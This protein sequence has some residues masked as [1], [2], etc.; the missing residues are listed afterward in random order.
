VCETTEPVSSQRP[1]GRANL[2]EWGRRATA[3]LPEDDESVSVHPG[4][5]AL[6]FVVVVPLRLGLEDEQVPRD[7]CALRLADLTGFD[8][9]TA[10]GRSWDQKLAA[11]SDYLAFG[12]PFR[13]VGESSKIPQPSSS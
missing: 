6:R 9:V 5:S 2:G 3:R 4:G 1:D 10:G 11:T 12:E 13:L 8:R 7:T